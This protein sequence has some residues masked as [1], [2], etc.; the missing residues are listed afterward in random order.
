MIIRR[1]EE[2]DAEAVSDLI[3]VTLRTTNRR[4]YSEEY[5]ENIVSRLQPDDMIRRAGGQHFYVAEE[6]TGII[7]C[8]AIGPCMDRT[9]ESC[10]FT[11]FVRPEYQGRG[12]GR[13]IMETLER[14]EYFLRAGR[15][16]IPASITGIPFYLKMGYTYKNGV[17]APDEEQLV[18]LE[19]FRRE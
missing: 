15:V 16:E 9:D 3:A 4:D 18:R 5:L 1:F 11:I 19:K 14:D 8:G 10:L 2:K 7:G 13:K 12:V 17:T 6:G